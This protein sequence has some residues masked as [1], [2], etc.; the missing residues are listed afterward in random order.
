MH[1]R[2]LASSASRKSSTCRPLSRSQHHVSD[3][4]TAS[5]Q[6]GVSTFLSYINKGERGYSVTIRLS[7]TLL[8]GSQATRLL[9]RTCRLACSSVPISLLPLR[10]QSRRC[11]SMNLGRNPVRLA[12]RFPSLQCLPSIVSRPVA[13]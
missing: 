12:L 8:T 6:L 1:V 3:F 13:K 5:G 2:K 10:Q 11:C 9:L 4:N 7:S